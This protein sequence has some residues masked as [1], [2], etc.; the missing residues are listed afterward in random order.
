MKEGNNLWRLTKVK[1]SY[2][3]LGLALIL[4]PSSI[5]LA[6][7]MPHEVGFWFAE[8]GQKPLITPDEINHGFFTN[9]TIEHL[10]Y[11]FA[12]NGV[13]SVSFFVEHVNETRDYWNDAWP[14]YALGKNPTFPASV[15]ES[16]DMT[17]IGFETLRN[18]ISEGGFRLGAGLGVG[19]GLGGSSANVR[20][21]V[22]G[23]QTNYSSATLWDALLVDFFIRARYSVYISDS[24]E[25]AIEL[26]GRYW[27]F[28][29][30]GP[31]ADGGNAYNGPGLRA[32]S[33]LGYM[34]GIAVG[35]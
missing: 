18:F 22:T 23:E 33:E 19:F 27:S 34:A 14:T 9:P 35:F 11:S 21:S 25:I 24:Y 13:Q 16:L 5:I 26:M 28:P 10:Y 7:N 1:L 4:H 6:Q 20:D 17:S 3:I 15:E 29:A 8:N 30:I 32:L 31:V 12:T 2:L